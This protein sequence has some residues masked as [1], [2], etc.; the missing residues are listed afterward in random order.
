M[1]HPRTR[2]GGELI[3]IDPRIVST[4]QQQAR[5]VTRGQGAGALSW[6][7]LLRRLDRQ[8]PGYDS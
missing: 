2:Q 6:P 3:P 7:G 5:E 1:P 8:M 4:A